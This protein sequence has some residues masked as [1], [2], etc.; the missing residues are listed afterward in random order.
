MLV[1]R[2]ARRYTSSALKIYK[3]NL[4]RL[5]NLV[6]LEVL[7]LYVLFHFLTHYLGYLGFE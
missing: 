4:R 6:L 7:P 5:P 3:L 1:L 2:F